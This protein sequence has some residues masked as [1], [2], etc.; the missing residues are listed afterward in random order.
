MPSVSRW[1]GYL[2][3]LMGWFYGPMDMSVIFIRK[4]RK[5]SYFTSCQGYPVGGGF[6]MENKRNKKTK[7]PSFSCVIYYTKGCEQFISE[8]QDKKVSMLRKHCENLTVDDVNH[9]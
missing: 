9:L 6:F 1:E 5:P 7:S 3:G 8:F 2:P 4:I